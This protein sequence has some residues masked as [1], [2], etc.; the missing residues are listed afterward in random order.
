MSRM[1]RTIAVMIPCFNEAATIGTVVAAVRQELPAAEV[2]VFDNGSTD[3]TP[4]AARQ[5]GARVMFETRRGKGFVVAAMLERVAADLYVLIDGDGTYPVAKVHDLLRPILAGEADQ[6]VGARHVED[7]S[8]AYQP[9]HQ[10][11]NR[12]VAFL[13]NRIFGT[14]FEDVMSGFRAFTVEVA[15]HVPFL[16]G[17]F[18]VETEF[19]LQTL[20]KGFVIAEVPV[21]FRERP[22]GSVS[23]LSTWRDGA[24]VLVRIVTILKDFRPFTFFGVLA[25]GAAGLS[26]A[27]GILPIRDYVVERYVHHVPLAIL[28]GILGSIAIGLLQ[29]GVVLATLNARLMEFH[30]L[31]RRS[32]RGQGT[33]NNDRAPGRLGS[34]R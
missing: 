32:R 34:E 18:D 2:Y 22:T 26:L 4:D 12:V 3:G 21:P 15:D 19:T 7:A 14:S 33:L 8:H 31:R 30:R 6:V 17:G 24:R 13:V 11:G 23:K 20:E 25:V 29:T 1:T 9:F 28:A 5:A 10:T 27:C 16:S